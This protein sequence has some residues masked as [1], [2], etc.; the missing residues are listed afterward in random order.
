MSADKSKRVSAFPIPSQESNPDKCQSIYWNMLCCIE[1]GAKSEIFIHELSESSRCDHIHN[2]EHVR[3][4]VESKA[5]T[6]VIQAV[7]KDTMDQQTI[8]KAERVVGHY[9]AWAENEIYK[10]LTGWNKLYYQTYFR[11]DKW[12]CGVALLGGSVGGLFKVY[13]RLATYK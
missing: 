1:A 5:T 6:L 13:Q 8:K 9:S 7:L 2:L 10:G 12:A 11:W 3:D 4:S